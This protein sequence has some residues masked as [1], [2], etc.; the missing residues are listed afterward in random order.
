MVTLQEVGQGRTK[1]QGCD[2]CMLHIGCNEFDRGWEETS[3]KLGCFLTP[4]SKISQF[5]RI[6]GYSQNFLI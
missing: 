5:L 4:S 3:L 2:L 6:D 1:T